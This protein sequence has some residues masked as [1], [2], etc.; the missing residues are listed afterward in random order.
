[1]STIRA[2]AIID[3]AGGNTATI[4]GKSPLGT[5]DLATQAEA[6]AGTDNTKVMTP[7]RAAQAIAALAP[8]PPYL[9]GSGTPTTLAVS[10]DVSYQ[11]TSG[12]PRLIYYFQFQLSSAIQ[13]QYELQFSHNGSTWIG[14]SSVGGSSAGTYG[15]SAQV[16]WPVNW[17]ARLATLTTGGTISNFQIRYY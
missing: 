8:I 10:R 16:Q 9:N 7:L 1:M 17:F 14:A 2:N 15:Q 6:Q 12:V 11:N 4:N 3:A 13:N 5:S